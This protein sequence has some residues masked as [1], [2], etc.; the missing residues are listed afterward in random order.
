MVENCPENA[1]MNARENVA[2]SYA[3]GLYSNLSLPGSQ[4]A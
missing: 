2:S 3:M 1:A 4:T